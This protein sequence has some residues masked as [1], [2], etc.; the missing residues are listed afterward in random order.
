MEIRPIKKSEWEKLQD[1]NAREYR[2]DHI[3]TNKTYYDWQFDN[4]FNGDHDSYTSLG[5]FDR[6]ENLVGT[7]GLFPASCNFFGRSIK[8]NWIA[9][10]MVRKNLRS[11]GYGTMLLKAAEEGFDLAVDHNVNDL[12]RPLFEKM[13]YK[14]SSVKRYICILNSGAMETLTDQEDLNFKIYKKK[15]VSDSSLEFKIVTHCDGEFDLFWEEIKARYPVSIDRSSKYL[16]WRY[17]DNPLVKYSIFTVSRGDK[18]GGFLVLRIEDVTSGTEKQPTGIKVGRMIDLIA[19]EDIEEQLVLQSIKYCQSQD[20]GL[21]DFFFTENFSIQS[22][23]KSGFIDAN[24]WPYSLIPTLLN[25]IDRV[26]R[27]QNNFAFK[28]INQNYFNKSITD[29]N[30]WYTT[31]GGGDQDR[32]Y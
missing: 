10:L 20:L 1:F 23:E 3:L 14:V 2:P 32:P 31:K 15:Q 8:C 29:P 12:A 25:P 6:K 22:L 21:I 28:L 26:K 11:L 7:I 27:T 16:N 30:N 18:L 4:V 5:L 9:N 13:G 24:I 19:R 17:A